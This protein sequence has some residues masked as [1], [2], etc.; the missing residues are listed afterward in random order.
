MGQMRGQLLA[1]RFARNRL[2]GP[3]SSIET[4]SMQRELCWTCRDREAFRPH[5]HGDDQHRRVGL[6][7]CGH[8]EHDERCGVVT[9][10]GLRYCLAG[11]LQ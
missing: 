7:R 2:G 1:R 9:D 6:R 5:V 8:G 4:K 10:G 3:I 11:R